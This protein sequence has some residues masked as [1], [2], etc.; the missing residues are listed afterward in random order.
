MRRRN[1]SKRHGPCNGLLRVN[2]ERRGWPRA[3]VGMPLSVAT[4]GTRPVRYIAHNLSAGGALL[5]AGPALPVG[6]EARVSFP[7]RGRALVLHARVM[8]ASL[9]GDGSPCL[10]LCFRGVPTFVQDLIQSHVQHALG[11]AATG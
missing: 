6:R 5:T 3:A 11:R 9:S 10:G 8:R 2:P 4:D 1:A 7:L